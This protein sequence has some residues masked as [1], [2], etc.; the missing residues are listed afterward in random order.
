[1]EISNW[2][3][4]RRKESQTSFL[5]FLPL[6]NKKTGTTVQ[7]IQLKIPGRLSLY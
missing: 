3:I 1:M 5:H 7:E 6:W 2:K 4:Q